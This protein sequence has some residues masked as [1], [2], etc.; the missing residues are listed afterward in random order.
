MHRECLR[1]RVRVCPTF[2]RYY[3][4]DMPPGCNVVIVCENNGFGLKP[5]RVCLPHQV[6]V[7]D[8]KDIKGLTIIPACSNHYIEMREPAKHLTPIKG[9]TR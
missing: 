7:K 4:F 8:V 2:G 6:Y 1:F 3:E 9:R 5:L